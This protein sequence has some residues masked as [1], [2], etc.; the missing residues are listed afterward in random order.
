VVSYCSSVKT[1]LRFIQDIEIVVAKKSRL[2]TPHADLNLR[3][4]SW[5]PSPDSNGW[6]VL[7]PVKV[8]PLS[9]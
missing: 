2:T 1:F 8:L 6:L 9:R 5:T 4:Y 7:V 3:I